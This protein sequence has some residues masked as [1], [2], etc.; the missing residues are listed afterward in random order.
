PGAPPPAPEEI[1]RSA[2]AAKPADARQKDER[3]QAPKLATA[4][5]PTNAPDSSSAPIS[6]TRETGMAKAVTKLAA[7]EDPEQRKAAVNRQ[8]SAAASALSLDAMKNEAGKKMEEANSGRE[9]Q[10]QR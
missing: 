8:T 9:L 10:T 5:A 3:P 2:T 1:A 4:D 7:V 6:Q